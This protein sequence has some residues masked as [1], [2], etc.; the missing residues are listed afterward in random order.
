MSEKLFGTDG[1]RGIPGEAPLRPLMVE[2]I[3]YHGAREL[4]RL[5]GVTPNGVRPRIALGRDTRGLRGR[6]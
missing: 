2:A 4:M 1:V 3:A 5:R 6:P